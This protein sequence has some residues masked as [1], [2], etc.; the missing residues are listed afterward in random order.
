MGRIKTLKARE[1]LDSS[2]N[3][4]L[5]GWLELDSGVMVSAQLPSALSA[6]P[7]EGTELRDGDL[8]RYHGQGVTIPVHYINNAIAQKITGVDISQRE[9]IDAWLL[10][11]DGTEK[12]QKL[13]VNTVM[14]I[15]MLLVKAEAASAG[16]P[17]YVFINQLL[18]KKFELDVQIQTI[19]S[20]IFNLMNGGSQ[21]TNHLNFHEFHIIPSTSTPY[22]DS[23]LLASELHTAIRDLFKQRNVIVP[24]SDEGGYVP[25][26]TSNFEALDII[27]ELVVGKKYKLGVDVFVGIDCVADTF[28]KDKK[29]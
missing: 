13:G 19:P 11:A 26:L 28:Y 16:V 27:Q 6:G 1:I 5:E 22:P 20:P 3:P 14:L 8:N 4:T 24:S 17:F 15:S 21:G 10:K 7:F 18:N 29:Y 12:L 23:L 9:D 2:G 25:T